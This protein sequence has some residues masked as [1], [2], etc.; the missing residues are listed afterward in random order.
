[1]WTIWRDFEAYLLQRSPTHVRLSPS[2]ADS[3]R[4]EQAQKVQQLLLD[5]L[6]EP[7]RGIEDTFAVYSSFVSAHDDANYETR[8][9][10]ANAVYRPSQAA[11]DRRDKREAQLSK[12]GSPPTAEAYVAYADWEASL[13]GASEPDSARLQVGV[14]Q[15]A[16]HD[17]GDRVEVWDAYL[18]LLVRRRSP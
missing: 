11:W 9:V 5:R 2:R 15:R 8:L 12:S 17:C 14:L 6:G 16:I 10:A 7:H 1:M 13:K 3:R 18:R 4:P